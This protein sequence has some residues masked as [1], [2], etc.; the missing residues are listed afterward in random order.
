MRIGNDHVRTAAPGC[1]AE[2]SSALHSGVCCSEGGTPSREPAGR[3]RYVA[4]ALFLGLGV[5]LPSAAAESFNAARAMQYT[6]EVVAF[7]A[8]PIGSANHKKLEHYIL[9]H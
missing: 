7:G 2:R 8:R 6:R 5:L 4:L 3:Q 1:P 9:N